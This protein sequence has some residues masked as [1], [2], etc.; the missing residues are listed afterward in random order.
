MTDLISGKS[1]IVS[2][3]NISAIV[4]GAASYHSHERDYEKDL[5]TILEAY[6]DALRK[7]MKWI[8]EY[9]AEHEFA[10]L[11]YETMYIRPAVASHIPHKAGITEYIF[12]QKVRVFLKE[13]TSVTKC[14]L[15]VLAEW[16]KKD[17]ET[18]LQNQTDGQVTD[19]VCGHMP[20]TLYKIVSGEGSNL[21]DTFENV[22]KKLNE[23]KI[24]NKVYDPASKKLIPAAN[25]CDEFVL[26]RGGNRRVD[27][28]VKM[29]IP[30]IYE[31]E[32]P[33]PVDIHE[34]PELSHA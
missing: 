14:P 21:R 30:F 33:H 11:V 13:I 26:L 28:G 10:A 22:L 7:A 5:Q 27:V 18:T 16:E 3:R 31:F 34:V 32:K 1:G 24:K 12:K 29:T 15:S 4:T 25:S 8:H 23:L 6:Q 19:N 17:R 2:I 20:C 9:D